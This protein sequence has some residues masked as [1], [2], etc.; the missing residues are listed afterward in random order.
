MKLKILYMKQIHDIDKFLHDEYDY[1]IL[2]PDKW[3]DYSYRTTFRVKIIRNEEEFDEFEVKLLFRGQDIEKS[4]FEII[5]ELLEDSNIIDIQSISDKFEFISLGNH[6]EEL[7]EIFDDGELD[8]LLKRLND[9]SYLKLIH[10]RQDLWDI[11]KEDGFETSLLRDQYSKRVYYEGIDKVLNSIKIAPKECFFSFS[12]NLGT[13]TYNYSF[14]FFDEILPS[15]INVL[16]GKNGVGKTKTLENLVDY[17][18]N[19]RNSSSKAVPHPNFLTNLCVFSY[20]PH[21]NFYIYKKHD[22]I[23]IEYKYLGFNR[24]KTLRDGIDI[25]D[26]QNDQIN[27]DILKTLHNDYQDTILWL[28]A[29]DPYKRQGH[30]E[31]L[32]TEINKNFEIDRQIIQNAINL[33]LKIIN[34]KISDSKNFDLISFNSF[35][36]LCEEDERKSKYVKKFYPLSEAYVNIISK[37]IPKI[38]NI[39]LKKLNGEIK[40]FTSFEDFLDINK[41]NFYQELFYFDENEKELNLSSGQK[42]YSNLLLN[43][44]SM[45]KENSLIIIDEP[46]NTLHPNF[47]IG[48]IKILNAILEKFNSFAIIATHSSIIAREIPTKFIKMIVLDED[49]DIVEIQKP[50]IKSFGASITDITNYIFDD[51]F[52]E[53]KPYSKWLEKQ[54][55]EYKKQLKDFEKFKKDYQEILS[56]ELLLEANDI[57]RKNTHV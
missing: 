23:S 42:M 11:T 49:K 45:I 54:V 39:G 37:Y 52:Y 38:D 24:Y 22:N 27:F 25:F 51:V 32:I 56:Y 33:N 53:N 13:R 43:L 16:I 1:Y 50:V 12:F 7:K 29:E 26:F 17:L 46:E 2:T 36:E 3:N 19:P 28:N 14:N 48:F 41:S 40:S 5:N 34:E 9:I 15:R 31:D 57:F 55:S 20:N 10:S 47:E 30:I 44:Y 21:D 4:S 35:I 8:Y 6:Y 18:I